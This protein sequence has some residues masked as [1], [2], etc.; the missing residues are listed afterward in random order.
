MTTLAAFNEMMGQF[1]G[2][3]AQT[4]PD[5]PKI[6]EVQAAPMNRATFDQFMKDITPMGL[7]DDGEG[8]SFL[9]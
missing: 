9:L 6:K 5:E 3:L 7:P 4:F 8:S 2:E 1:I